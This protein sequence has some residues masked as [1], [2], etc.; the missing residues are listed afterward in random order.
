ML[1]NRPIPRE[2]LDSV[3]GA[4]N[5]P[6][7]VAI[8]PLHLRHMAEKMGLVESSDPQAAKTIATLQRRMVA[9]ASRI[10]FSALA[11]VESHSTRAA[12]ARSTFARACGLSLM[13]FDVIGQSATL[14]RCSW[15]R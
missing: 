1:L 9:L 11:V 10:C 15:W 6:E 12:S 5:S 2:Q 8:H 7:L 4:S 14:S 3:A 13:W